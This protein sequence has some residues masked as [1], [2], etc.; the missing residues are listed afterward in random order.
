MFALSC[1]ADNL[2]LQMPL[3]IIIFPSQ[4]RICSLGA[5]SLRAA[6]G[7]LAGTEREYFNEWYALPFTEQEM[8]HGNYSLHRSTMRR[9]SQNLP[10]GSA[11]I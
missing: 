6:A 3:S 4:T 2:A 11:S 8:V 7:V 5:R 9:A 1:Y 10:V